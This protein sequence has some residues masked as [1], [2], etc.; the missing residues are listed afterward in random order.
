MSSKKVVTVSE[1]IHD[2]MVRYKKRTGVMLTHLVDRAVSIF[3]DNE[4]K[5]G[6]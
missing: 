2:R 3:L 5:K 4:E 6:K 1:R